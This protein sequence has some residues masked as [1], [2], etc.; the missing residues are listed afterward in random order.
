MTF[1]SLHLH[2]LLH[3][4]YMYLW[5]CPMVTLASYSLTEVKGTIKRDLVDSRGPTL[6]DPWALQ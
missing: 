2:G 5:S 4:L 3:S 1:E 6:G